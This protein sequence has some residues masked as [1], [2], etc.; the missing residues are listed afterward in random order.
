MLPCCKQATC[1]LCLPTSH[2]EINNTKKQK[3]VCDMAL[4]MS[5]FSGMADFESRAGMS[6]KLLAPGG[7]GAAISLV[8]RLLSRVVSNQPLGWLARI[9]RI[10]KSSNLRVGADQADYYAIG[11]LKTNQVFPCMV[12]S[13]TQA[14]GFRFSHPKLA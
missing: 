2:A 5:H 11:K 14:P 7:A 3:V 9:R 8:R 13:P 6:V 1:S 10:P 4:F 12:L